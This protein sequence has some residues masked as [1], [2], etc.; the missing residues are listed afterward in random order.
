MPAKF[1]PQRPMGR[2]KGLPPKHR[3]YVADHALPVV[4]ELFSAQFER[5]FNLTKIAQTVGVDRSLLHRMARGHNPSLFLV[6]AV[7]NAMGLELTLK[8]KKKEST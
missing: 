5:G 3:T 4:H 1:D 7:A 2:P 8:I 6:A